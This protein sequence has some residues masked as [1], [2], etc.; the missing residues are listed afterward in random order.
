MD[1]KLS[2]AYFAFSE[3]YGAN[4]AGFTHSYN[5]VYS[6]SKLGLKVKAFFR[7]NKNLPNEGSLEFVNIIFPSLNVLFKFNPF[8]YFKSYTK[9]TNRLVSFI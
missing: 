3:D 4:H 6:L 2:I 1:E 5:I 8:N 9:F 7:S